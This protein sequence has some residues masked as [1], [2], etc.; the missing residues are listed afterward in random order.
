M[1]P[2]L[3]RWV[4]PIQRLHARAEKDRKSRL[5]RLYPPHGDTVLRGGRRLGGFAAEIPSVSVPRSRRRAAAVRATS[6]L[7]L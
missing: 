1:P 7:R 4:G 5:Q 6:T 2:S 3:K